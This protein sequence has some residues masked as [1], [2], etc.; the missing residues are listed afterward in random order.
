MSNFLENALNT[1]SKPDRTSA[2]D[3]KS[4][5]RIVPDTFLDN[6]PSDV[7]DSDKPAESQTP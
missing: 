1:E 6:T 3:S 7:L 4:E 2:A 5:E